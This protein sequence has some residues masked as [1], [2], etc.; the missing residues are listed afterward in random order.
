MFENWIVILVHQLVFQ[1]MFM[2][3]NI[4]LSKK[5]GLQIRGKNREA[6]VSILFFAV[7]ITLSLGFSFID[8][9]PGYINL[10][11][12][13]TALG[14]AFVILLLN[15]IIST[16]SLI[17]LKDSWRVGVVENQKT[18]LVSSGIYRFT[19]N[20]Y[21]VSYLLMFTGYT[22]LLQNIILLI[23]S[24]TGFLFIHQMIIKEEQ[25]LISVHGAAYTQYHKSVPRYLFI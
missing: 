8:S 4:L 2:T 5:T 18:E 6:S 21:F 24:L 11:P 14:L 10:Y 7:F 13:D 22:L 9:P 15:L 1:G 20:P 17:E 23:L 25:F 19:R 12:H 16:I 3:K